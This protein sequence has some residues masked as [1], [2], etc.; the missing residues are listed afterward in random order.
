VIAAAMGSVMSWMN[1][2]GLPDVMNAYSWLWPVME[3]LHFVG[4]ALLIGTVGLLDLRLLGLA[5][6]L[7][8][9]PFQRLVPW[10]LFGFGINAITGV[11][12]IAGNRFAPVEYGENIAFQL[13]LLFMLLAAVNAT[14]FY[15]TGVARRVEA[16]GPGDNAPASAKLIAATGLSLWVGVICFGRLLPYLGDA[17]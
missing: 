16:L 14:A 3:M 17:F 4:M 2:S 8:P 6:A 1:S 11:L 5:K 10:G 9:A 15:V 12:F 13:K 7:P